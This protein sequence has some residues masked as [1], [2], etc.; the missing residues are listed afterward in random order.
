MKFLFNIIS[1]TTLFI[2]TSCTSHEARQESADRVA[3]NAGFTPHMVK[4]GAFWLQTYQ[5]VSNPSLPY[6]IYIESD[7][8]A[9]R[10]KVRVSNDPTPIRPMLLDLATQDSRANVIYLARPCQYGATFT[11]NYC[12]NSYWTSKRMSEEVVNS[13][14]V[15]VKE[16]S[17][18]KPV[19]LIGYSG[20][21]GI[22]VL[23]AARN[24]QT[25]SIITIAGNLDHVRFN[26]HHE[27]SRMIGSLNPIDVATKVNH[28]P[29]IHYTGSKD[30]VIPSFITDHFIQVANSSC[31]KHEIIPKASHDSGW[32]KSWNY[33]LSTPVTCLK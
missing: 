28:I 21:G 15:A 14:N 7:G 18:G 6:V 26:K 29:Q 5:K 4:A 11:D 3:E 2:L 20:G 16:L 31:V 24:P 12:N 25:R 9:F 23:V 22:A 33:I 19:D 8:F 32:D 30:E 17:H 1:I 13:I 27:T 10:N